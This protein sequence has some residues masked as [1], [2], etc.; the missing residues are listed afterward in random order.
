MRNL[1]LELIP[2]A[3]H[4][5]LYLSPDIPPGKV[6]NA[7][8]D[9]A[10]SIHPEDVLALYDATLLGNAKDG[11]VFTS[12]RFVFQ[13]NDLEPA[14]NIRYADLVHVERKRR[15]LGGQKVHLD[16]NRGRATV[17]VS[18]DFSGKS[19][20]AKYIERFLYEAMLHGAALEMDRGD[21]LTEQD[22]ETDYEAVKNALDELLVQRKLSKNDYDRIVKLLDK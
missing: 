5:G 15:L 7:I 2:H 22:A 9:Y 18:I 12:D 1:I 20:A 4:L 14:Q 11:A 13:N 8:N 17:R 21:V 3:P 16:F 6:K 19:D 10:R